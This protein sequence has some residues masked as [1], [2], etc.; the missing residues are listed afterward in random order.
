MSNKRQKLDDNVESKFYK[1]LFEHESLKAIEESFKQSKPYL[2]CKIDQL[3]ED[4]LLRRVQKE[5][6]RSLHFTLKETDIYKV[7]QTGDLA[8]LDGLPKH[9]LEQLSS[10]FELRNSIYSSE[11]RSFIS[12]VTGCGPLSG[13]KMDMSINSYQTGCHLLNHDDVI[14]TRRVS[15]IL[16]LT[17]PD[18]PWLPKEGGALEL[19][20]VI[21]K[22]TPAS[23]PTVSIPPQWNQFVMFTVQPGHSFHSVEEVVGTGN[24]LSISGWFHIPQKGEIGYD[25]NAGNEEDVAKSSLQQLQEEQNAEDYYTRYAVQNPQEE[26]IVGLTEDV[27]VDLAEWMNPHYLDLKVISQMS[28]KFLDESAIQCKQFLSEATLARLESAT[29][30]LDK[31]DNL[32]ENKEGIV[33]HGTGVTKD[34]VVQ[35]PPHQLRYMIN[36]STDKNDD[37]FAYLR[38]KFESESFRLW[39]N[40]IVQILPIGYRGEA[41]RFRPGHDY[42][43][44]TTNKRSQGVLDVT[45]CTVDKAA[46][47]KDGDIGGY[48]CYMAP[49]DDEEDPAT[50]KAADEDGALLTLPAGHNELSI[51]LRDEGV[52]R[53]IKYVSA[54]SPGSRW[55]IC[56]E[57]DL[58]DKSDDEEE[59]E[60][61]NPVYIHKPLQVTSFLFI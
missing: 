11:F 49:H 60:V 41:R 12:Q 44:A 3:F 23:E 48:E 59:Q 50:Y 29:I 42:T 32:Y 16:Y 1:G 4:G 52:M 28:E 7:L 40:S 18:I 47:W 37:I 6:L 57:Y 33:P 13:S 54:K 20:P 14:G 17:D 35:G 5:I 43:L 51:V 53:F 24:R 27:L 46:L 2:H 45:F 22:G 36:K 8:N 38:S 31:K 25:P 26:E 15:Y 61:E 19:Y 9:E 10:L 21:K 30:A 34:W 55:D 56:Y 58:P 39:L